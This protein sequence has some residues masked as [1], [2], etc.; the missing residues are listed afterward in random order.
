MAKLADAGLKG[1]Q[2]G[3]VKPAELFE[4]GAV[5][6]I[7]GAEYSSFDGDPQVKFHIE[8]DG[9]ETSFSLS[10]SDYR[11]KFITYFADNGD[12]IEGVHL[13]QI[14]KKKAWGFDDGDFTPPEKSSDSD[15]VPF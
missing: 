1:G 5:F 9:K 3:F 7:I 4:Q 10:M 11:E 15:D 2:G 8:L 6:D 13:V 12:R 14:G